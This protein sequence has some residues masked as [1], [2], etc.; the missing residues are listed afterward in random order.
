MH[1]LG[2]GP[3]DT[4]EKRERKPRSG[5]R[6]IG[7]MPASHATTQICRPLRGLSFFAV[8][9]LGPLLQFKGRFLF[10]L[11]N[12]LREQGLAQDVTMPMPFALLHYLPIIKANRVPNRFSVV[13]SLALAVLV[14]YGAHWILSR[15]ASGRA[16]RRGAISLSR[17]G[18]GL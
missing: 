16:A 18:R 9:T 10:P 13:L 5:D 14:G 8:F 1:S 6:Y 4:D 17:W 7:A 12:L 11:D 3:Q 15:A 2:R